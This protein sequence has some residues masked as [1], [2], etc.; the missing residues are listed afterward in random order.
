M[1]DSLERGL[2]K[3][4]KNSQVRYIK[5][6]EKIL[7]P[8]NEAEDILL[9]DE[10]LDDTDERNEVLEFLRGP[11]KRN[12]FWAVCLLVK[13]TGVVK[14]PELEKETE[15]GDIEDKDGEETDGDDEGSEVSRLIDKDF[16]G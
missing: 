4:H 6:Y 12:G 2:P 13:T 16:P 15:D 5:E 8:D 11:T 14:L 3:D 1:R 7:L 9:W 10:T